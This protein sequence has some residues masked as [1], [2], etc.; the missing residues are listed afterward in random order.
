MSTTTTTERVE[1]VV[2]ETIEGFGPDAE[3]T[4]DATFEALDVDSL[5]LVEL[6]QIVDDEFGV[7]LEASDVGELKT[8]GDA[9]DLVAARAS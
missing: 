6:G 9:I 5:D 3:V 1:R 7:K 2:I 8:V 4:R